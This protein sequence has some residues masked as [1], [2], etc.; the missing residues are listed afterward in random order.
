MGGSVLDGWVGGSVLD[1]LGGSVL[2]ALVGGPVQDG[3]VIE[4]VRTGWVSWEG[5]YLMG[6]WEGL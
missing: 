5:L 1:W 3:L 6:W 4:W 2:H